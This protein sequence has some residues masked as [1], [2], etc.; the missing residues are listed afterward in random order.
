MTYKTILF[1]ADMTLFDFKKAEDQALERTLMAHGYPCS[2]QVKELY[3]T[4]NEA[5]W[6]SFERGEITKEALLAT[7]FARLF[8]GP[9][10]PDDGIDFNREYLENLGDGAFLTDGALELCQTLAR[11]ARLYIITNG[12]THT[13]KK[14]L[15]LSELAPYI[16][17]IFV[18]EETGSQKPFLPYFQYVAEHIP[19]WDPAT[20]LVVGDSLTSDIQGAINAGLDCC[21]FNP[22]GLPY[23]LATPCTCQISR[24][25][26]LVPLVLE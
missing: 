18:S 17:G 6:R 25:S 15:R 4:I 23:T 19:D 5:L 1:D 10:I 14:R 8:Q 13:Q 20:T 16:Q 9:N 24:L 22:Q 21:W 2:P 11:S 12:V 26:Q 3:I 7:R